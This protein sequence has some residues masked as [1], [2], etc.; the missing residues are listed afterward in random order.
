MRT[1]FA[2]RDMFSRVL[3]GGR[4]SLTIGFTSMLTALAIGTL[5][6]SI[7]DL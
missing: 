1:D 4:V 6:G 2:G 3:Y 7:A 5:L